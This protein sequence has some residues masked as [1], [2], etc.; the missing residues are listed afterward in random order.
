MKL[1]GQKPEWWKRGEKRKTSDGDRI[2]EKKDRKNKRK[3][4]LLTMLAAGSKLILDKLNDA[5]ECG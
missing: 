2:K 4:Q 5:Q 3:Y 1:N